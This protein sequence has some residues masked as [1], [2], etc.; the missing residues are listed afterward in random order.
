[1]STFTA[2]G[3][4]LNLDGPLPVAPEYSLLKTLDALG[5]LRVGDREFNGVNVWGYP[6][7]TGFP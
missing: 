2:V 7:E 3:P 4:A 6:V 5:Y 1:M